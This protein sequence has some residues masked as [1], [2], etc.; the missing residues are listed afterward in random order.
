VL[1]AVARELAGVLCA[2]VSR[3]VSRP[4]S[5]RVV[6]LPAEWSTA[7]RCHDLAAL[8]ASLNTG[9]SA[10][11]SRRASPGG[12][13]DREDAAAPSAR[14]WHPTQRLIRIHASLDRDFVRGVFV[15]SIVFHEMLHAHLGVPRGGGRR[16][17]HGR[18]FRERNAAF[19][20][21]AAAR[22]WIGSNLERLLR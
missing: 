9:T 1:R 18:A 11:P 7:G 10:G 6:R 22:A 3:I 16:S 19:P 21:H 13:G 14:S 12:D 17:L 2:F 5:R 20:D 8:F 15:A 4:R